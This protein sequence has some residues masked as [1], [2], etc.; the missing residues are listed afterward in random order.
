MRIGGMIWV[1]LAFVLGPF[2]LAQT[3]SSYPFLNDL[4]ELS[5][6]VD[7]GRTIYVVG[8]THTSIR[9]KDNTEEVLA[10]KKANEETRKLLKDK[11]IL[12][13]SEFSNRDEGDKNN[14]Y[15]KYGL[16]PKTLKGTYRGLEEKN[17]KG[18]TLIALL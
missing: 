2:G 5:R 15:R 12:F 6:I 17:A 3:K 16:D 8:E 13:L 9:A 11:E 1:F 4:P 14:F 18:F 10:Y 7:G